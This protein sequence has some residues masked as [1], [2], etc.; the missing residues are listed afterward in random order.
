M[1]AVLAIVVVSLAT[2]LRGST[3]G[4][5]LGI[6]LNN[7]LG[8]NQSLSQL[9]NYWTQLETSLGA[10]ARLKTFEKETTPEEREGED[11]QPSEQWPE[12]GAVEFK[13]VSASYGQ[14]YLI[15]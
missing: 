4:G 1:I 3:S 13:N 2:S 12:Y 9:V 8:F 7:I 15:A 6:A 14:V 10:I 5:L 11:V